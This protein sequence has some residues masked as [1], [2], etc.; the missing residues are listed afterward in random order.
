M[1]AQFPRTTHP[2][3]LPARPA[4]GDRGRAR[5]RP[6]LHRPH[7]HDP[8]DPGPRLARRR[9]A[10]VRPAHARPRVDGAALRP[11]DLR[12]AQG[13]PPARRLDRLVPARRQRRAVPRL[14]GAAGHGAAARRAVPRLARGAARR[15]PRV[16]A[17]RGRRGVDV[18]AAVHDGRRGRAGGAA[19]G[20]VP[21]LPDRL[22][23][24]PVLP[25]RRQAR[26]RV[27]EHGLHARRARRHRHRQVR[28]QLRRLPAAPGPGRRARLRAGGLPRRRGAPLDRRDGLE[29]P[30]L[31]LRLGRARRGRDALAHRQHP[32]RRSPATRCW[33]WPRSWAARSPSDG[34]RGTSGARAPR[35]GGSP[36]S[37]AA[38]RP[39]WSPRSAGSGT[40]AARS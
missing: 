22:A 23:G 18:P 21:V 35:T 11:G 32:A 6:V 15:R 33:C 7:G 34:S 20:G 12:G 3:P 28:R 17:A 1:S 14:G 13:L 19:V 4:G 30:V 27:A 39:R 9:R 40:T 5:L 38:A 36:R 16:G 26:R 2:A 37:S 25:G 10:A 29:Q 31:R 24:R 8:L